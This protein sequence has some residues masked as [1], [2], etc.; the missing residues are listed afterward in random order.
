MITIPAS[1]TSKPTKSTGKI[2]FMNSSLG[3]KQLH[4][5]RNGRHKDFEYTF[6]APAAGKYSL[7]ARVVT[8]SWKQSLLLVVNDA[9]RSVEIALPF[10]VT[11]TSPVGGEAAPDAVTGAGVCP[12]AAVP[13]AVNTNP[14]P[15]YTFIRSPAS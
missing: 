7:T 11:T 1:A 12:N 6:E 5:S 14:M 2:L 10:T 8:P 4:Y 13:T 3:G 15:T 9:K